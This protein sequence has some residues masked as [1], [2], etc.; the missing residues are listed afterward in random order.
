MNS[1]TICSNHP[2]KK[3]FFACTYKD[4]QE[5]YICL[6]C[7]PFHNSSHLSRFLNISETVEDN[8]SL[9]NIVKTKQNEVIKKLSQIIGEN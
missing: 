9:I 7:I 1:D 2:N 4:C 6:T 5:P 8:Q 3:A